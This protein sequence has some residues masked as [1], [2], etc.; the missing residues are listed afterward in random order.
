MRGPAQD[1]P[2]ADFDQAAYPILT[3]HFFAVG[4]LVPISQVLPAVFANLTRTMVANTNSPQNHRNKDMNEQE[5]DSLNTV[6]NFLWRDEQKHFG[7]CE[8]ND[9]GAPADHI[10][11]HLETLRRYV[12]NERATDVSPF[13]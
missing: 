2:P 4:P 11:R 10:F 12:A 3:R 6:V 5:I 9:G 1:L 7:E 13:I 8:L